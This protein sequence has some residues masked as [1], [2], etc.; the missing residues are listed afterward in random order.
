MTEITEDITTELI[1]PSDYLDVFEEL[2]HS[3]ESRFW[4]LECNQSYKEPDDP[5]YNAFSEGDFSKAME[6]F[7]D[8]IKHEEKY[9]RDIPQK[10]LDYT[11]VRVISEP[12]T[13]YTKYEI[14]T[15]KISATYGQRIF[16]LNSREARK[17]N[18]RKHGDIMLFDTKAFIILKYH[19]DGSLDKRLLGKVRSECRHIRKVADEAVRSSTSLGSYISTKKGYE[20]E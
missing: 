14:G 19:D 2:W 16:L 1:T 17:L 3:L 8:R 20:L 12:L 9:L 11:R 18:L 5:S 15:Y 4:K 10:N 6:L 7:Q 13:N